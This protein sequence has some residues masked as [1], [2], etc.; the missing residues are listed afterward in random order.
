MSHGALGRDVVMCYPLQA[1]AAALPGNQGS[2]PRSLPAQM[3]PA[4]TQSSLFQ[5]Q[6]HHP[7]QW[8]E[9]GK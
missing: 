3:C 7:L 5:G 1:L 4:L 9:T 2:P 8:L 6:M